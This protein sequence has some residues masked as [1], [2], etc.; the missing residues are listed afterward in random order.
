M[1]TWIL[2][3]LIVGGYDSGVAVDHIEFLHKQDCEIAGQA[4]S[5]EKPK[6]TLRVRFG[7]VCVQKRSRYEKQ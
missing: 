6:S 7:Y 4:V 2:I 3:L 1:S 5:I